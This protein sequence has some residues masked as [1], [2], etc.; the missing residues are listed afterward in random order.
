MPTLTDLYDRIVQ[1]NNGVPV[2]PVVQFVRRY[3][4]LNPVAR[5]VF[6]FGWGLVVTSF[7]CKLYREIMNQ[8][9]S[10]AT[11]F[12]YSEFW[13]CLND[14]WM[15]EYIYKYDNIYSKTP[16]PE[17]LL[18]LGPTSF[19]G[20]IELPTEEQLADH[21]G[22]TMTIQM[23]VDKGYQFDMEYTPVSYVD[24]Y[25]YPDSLDPDEDEDADAEDE[26]MLTY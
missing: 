21:D 1:I 10:K 7:T 2:S 23:H 22:S 19:R 9:W 12:E 20:W 3:P 25:D 14:G 4:A 15:Q 26:E 24:T 6:Q 17:R 8:T 16:S 13:D 5:R 11:E 18:R